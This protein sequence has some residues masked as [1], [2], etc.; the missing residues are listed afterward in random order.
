MNIFCVCVDLYDGWV[1]ELRFDLLLF[2][3]VEHVCQDGGVHG[4]TCGEKRVE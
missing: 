2:H 3:H 4:Q 1:E